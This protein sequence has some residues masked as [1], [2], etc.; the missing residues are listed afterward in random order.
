MATQNIKKDQQIL[1]KLYAVCKFGSGD[2]HFNQCWDK[3]QTA[4]KELF[5]KYKN[6]YRTKKGTYKLAN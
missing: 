3:F 2:T 6:S 5:A 1:N 4:R